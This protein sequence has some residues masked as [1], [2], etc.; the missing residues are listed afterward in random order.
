MSKGY[1]SLD[2]TCNKI[3][4]ACYVVFNESLF[5]F[6]QS[7]FSTNPNTPFTTT[8]SLWF[9]NSTSGS[10]SDNDSSPSASI[11]LSTSDFGP[12]SS[13]LDFTTSLL[14]SLL[15]TSTPIPMVPPPPPSS[16]P[17]SLSNIS[18]AP[19][20][21][22]LPISSSVVPSTSES[23]PTSSSNPISHNSHPMVTR[24][25]HGM[26]KPK[27][28]SVQHDYTQSEPPSYAIAAKHSQ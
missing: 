28:L 2:P 1:I 20:S 25:K 17:S 15:H 24:S 22:S 21:S 26:Y 18:T 10:S 19:T 6:A 13:S 5:P 27:V 3:Y 4:I 11:P 7:P 12:S 8:V 9:P 14:P 23:A 16:L